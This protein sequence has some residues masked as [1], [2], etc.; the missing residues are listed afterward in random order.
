MFLIANMYFTVFGFNG[1]QQGQLLLRDLKLAQNAH[2]SPKCTFTAQMIGCVIGA[3]FKYVL[4]KPH[5][6][7][8][9]AD[10]PLAIS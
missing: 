2:L 3:I 8:R 6:R 9:L 5:I 1:V 10:P 7:N 4:V